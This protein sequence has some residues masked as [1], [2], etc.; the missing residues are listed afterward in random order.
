MKRI[1]HLYHTKHDRSK[2]SSEKSRRVVTNVTNNKETSTRL[3][4]LTQRNRKEVDK[5]AIKKVL[6]HE[7]AKAY[8]K[9]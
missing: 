8:V 4:P 6:K 5:L 7:V 9:S 2:P 1:Q 3:D